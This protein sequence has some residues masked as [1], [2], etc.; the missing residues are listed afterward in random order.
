MP[1][2]VT[3]TSCADRSAGR[4]NAKAVSD[5]CKTLEPL[6]DRICG[7]TFMSEESSWDRR[8]RA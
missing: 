1:L 8:W 3:G 7:K 2:V 5:V 4:K 6:S